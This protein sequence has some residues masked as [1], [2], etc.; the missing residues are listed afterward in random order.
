MNNISIY[1]HQSL[2][3]FSASIL[4]DDGIINHL[5]ESMSLLAFCEYEEGKYR[6]VYTDMD[7]LEYLTLATLLNEPTMF[8]LIHDLIDKIEKERKKGVNPFLLVEKMAKYDSIEYV[9]LKRY[10]HLYDVT[11]QQTRK[12]KLYKAN[13]KDKRDIAFNGLIHST[14]MLTFIRDGANELG[15]ANTAINDKLLFMLYTLFE[16]NMQVYELFK[17]AVLDVLNYQKP[18][19]TYDAFTAKAIERIKKNKNIYTNPKD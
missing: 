4:G 18:V 13:E 9:Q 1:D 7:E 3:T 12:I 17:L 10:K 14:N 16:N 2:R 5:R 6:M 11:I 15:Y 19:C 8:K